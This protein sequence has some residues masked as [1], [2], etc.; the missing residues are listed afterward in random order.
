[1]LT[2][3]NC[4]VTVKSVKGCGQQNMTNLLAVGSVCQFGKRSRFGSKGPDFSTVKFILFGGPSQ[5]IFKLSN[6]QKMRRKGRHNNL[7]KMISNAFACSG[8]MEMHPM[9]SSIDQ[10]NSECDQT[11]LRSK[12]Q[13]DNKKPYCDLRLSVGR[14]FIGM[15]S[16]G[17]NI[18]ENNEAKTL[19]DLGGAWCT[20][21]YGTQFFCFR[22]DFHQ[23]VPV[24]E[25]HIP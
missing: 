10:Y 7:R 3:P 6:D 21:P 1:M 15:A 17:S 12:W 9:Q 14:Q 23:K 20:P 11:C 22:I 25:V 5:R 18:S 19:S 8:V 16:C 2:S 24:S 13:C 4:L